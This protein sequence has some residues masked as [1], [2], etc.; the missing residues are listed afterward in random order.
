MP[1]FRRVRRECDPTNLKFGDKCPI[2]TE[3]FEDINKIIQLKCNHIFHKEC[4]E[5]WEKI[6]N[7]CPLC[8]KP[9][10]HK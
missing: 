10:V 2:C 5:H 6:K 1:Y 9:I 7:S 8:R 3:E 4:I